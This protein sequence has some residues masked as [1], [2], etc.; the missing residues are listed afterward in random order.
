MTDTTTPAG[1]MPAVAGAMPAQSAPAQSDPA[2]ATA[3][4]EQLG[5]AGIGTIQKLRSELKDAR[6]TARERD[7]LKAEIEAMK[8]AGASDAE[9]AIAKAKADG[10]SEVT[11]HFHDQ[12]RRSEV[13]LALS[14]AGVSPSLLDLMANASEFAALK[15]T[16]DGTIDPEAMKAAMSVAKSS[17]A[18]LFRPPQG[19]ADGGPRG[20]TPAGRFYKASELNDRDFYVKNQADIMRAY[21]ENRILADQ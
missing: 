1:A 21:R 18:D 16:D 6:A 13:K 8:L 3:A 14:A 11:G 20:S 19:S 12:I 7:A 4:D 10:A 5:D 2:A 17:R 9:K 15:V